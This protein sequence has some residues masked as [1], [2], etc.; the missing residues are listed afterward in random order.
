MLQ[1][2]AN[3]RAVSRKWDGF[4]FTE[5]FQFLLR[6]AIQR[7]FTFLLKNSKLMGY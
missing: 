3:K 7:E 2:F 6:F 1:W 4:F 5:I